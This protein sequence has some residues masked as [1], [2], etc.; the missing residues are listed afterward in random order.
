MSSDVMF[1]LMF[2]FALAI[3]CVFARVVYYAWYWKNHKLKNFPFHF[4]GRLF[5]FSRSIAAVGFFFKKVGDEIF[6][7]AEKRG[8]GAADF[9]GK[10]CVPCGYLDFDETIDECLIR[11]TREE[12]GF[13]VKKGELKLLS[14][15]SSPT[16]NRQNVSVHMGN[17]FTEDR[18]FDETYQVGG[19]KDEVSGIKWVKVGTINEEKVVTPSIEIPH[20]EWAFDHDV[21]ILKYLNVLFKQKKSKKVG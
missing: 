11:E 20:E 6:V 16:Q 18:D 3:I 13:E 1:I 8:K 12:C 15:N 9:Q 10:W 7:L 2:C 14:I 21:N 4:N 19:E 17:V 5:W